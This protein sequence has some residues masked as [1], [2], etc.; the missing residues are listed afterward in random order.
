MWLVLSN[1]YKD[2]SLFV[3]L[4]ILTFI[5]DRNTLLPAGFSDKIYPKSQKNSLI[6]ENIVNFFLN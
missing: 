3:N 4:F 1:L 5:M 6:I 2:I